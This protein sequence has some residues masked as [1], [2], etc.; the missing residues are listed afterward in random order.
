MSMLSCR[1]VESHG[2][3]AAVFGLGGVACYLMC[4]VRKRKN[5]DQALGCA[6]IDADA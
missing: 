4:H 6:G 5:E 3:A 1:P 2:P